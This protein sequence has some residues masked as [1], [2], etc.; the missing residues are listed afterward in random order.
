[1]DSDI[2]IGVLASLKREIGPFLGLMDKVTRK[3]HLGR[4][5]WEGLL[6]GVTVRIITTGIATEPPVDLLH[7]CS[8]LLST[9]FCGALSGT[10][11]TGDIVVSSSVAYADRDHVRRILNQRGFSG[12]FEGS[13]VFDIDVDDELLSIIQDNLSGDGSFVH[14][15]RTVTCARVVKNREEK[16]KIGTYY[17]ALAVDMEDYG[18]LRKARLLATQMW[19]IRAVLDD[20]ADTVPGPWSGI[21]AGRLS[22]FLHKIPTAQRSLCRMLAA[23]I[24][25]M[26]EKMKRA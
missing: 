23:L 4:S 16:G 11:N 18:R 1:M 6:G 14:I 20:S 26:F 10:V 25:V 3:R 19:C 15:G 21:G 22:T 8:L 2:I 12:S 13:G 5:M 9:G 7:G 17:D 24:P